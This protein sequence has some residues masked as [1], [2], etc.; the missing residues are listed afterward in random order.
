MYKKH[1]RIIDILTGILLAAAVVLI[2]PEMFSIQA[3]VALGVI[4]LMVFWWITRPVH[5]A[6]TALI[7][8]IANSFFPHK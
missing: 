5:L 1:K 4:S 2:L 8:I 6:V 7:P 3:K